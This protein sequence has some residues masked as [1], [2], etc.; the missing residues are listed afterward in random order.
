MRAFPFGSPRR[1]A[2]LGRALVV[3][4]VLAGLLSAGAGN[5]IHVKRGDTLSQLAKRYHTTVAALREL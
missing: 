4:L 1:A 5:V 3:P 2:G